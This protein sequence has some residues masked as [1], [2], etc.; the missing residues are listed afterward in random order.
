MTI[1]ET[2][3]H[4]IL[5]RP[6]FIIGA[7]FII[8]ILI[9]LAVSILI[10]LN[11][12]RSLEDREIEQSVKR[13][14]SGLANELTQLYSV[15]DDYA[16]W[17]DS[18]RF[19]VDGN[20][21]FIK[22]DLDDTIFPKLRLNLIAFVNPSGRI[23]YEKGFDLR[24]NKTVPV[25]ASLHSRIFAGSPLVRHDSTDSSLSGILL[26]P[27]GPLLVVSRPILTSEYKGPVRGALIMGRFL[28]S[29][30]TSLLNRITHL[31]M[32]F[33]PVNDP[34]V[35]SDVMTGSSPPDEKVRIRVLRQ[36]SDSIAGYSRLRDIY[37][38]PALILRV[39]MPRN[40]FRQGV[41]TIRYFVVS[42]FGIS[43][44]AVVAGYLL[45][46]KLVLTRRKQRESEARYH[47][48]IKQA[49]DGIMLVDAGSKRL[50][51]A[52]DTL[53][54]L[55][56]YSEN[57]LEGMTLED[58][59]EASRND[60]D[61]DIE[62]IR[63]KKQYFMGERYLRRKTGDLVI[64][65]VGANF[66]SVGDSEV[67]CIVA[68][69]ITERKRAEEKLRR[70]HD[71]LEKRV[72]ERTAELRAKDQLLLQQSRQAAMG[73]MIGNIA[74]QW[75]Q[76]L[77]ALGIIVQSL[78]ITYE[79]GELSTEYL[80]S[81]ADSA[82]ELISHMSQTISDFRNYFKPDKEKVPFNVRTAVSKTISL[83]ED[84]F[85]NR[86]I[87]I[88]INQQD[89]PVIEGYPN[90]YS[91]VLLNILLNARDVIIERGVGTP[92]VAVTISSRNGKAL[93]TITDNAGGIPEEIIDKIFDPY[94]TTKDP[95]KGTGVG[96][97]MSKSIIEKNM[98][99]NLTVQNT[100][101]GA[102]FR[103]EV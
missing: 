69:D 42:I 9:Q 28:D 55:V 87:A 24:N 33:L 44:I 23:V 77:N 100:G 19:I 52:N 48:V 22:T 64:V 31:S 45:H 103:I 51:E 91:Q 25:P 47:A 20:A 18:Y 2:N 34:R 15:A 16:G 37:G 49:S 79:D 59:L 5:K 41:M 102:M 89:D 4:T 72:M 13:A 21:A 98:E 6:Q 86:Q 61:R 40:V 62:N 73:E 63:S 76:P 70:T 84:S 54:S 56:G 81:M 27:E 12:Y 94:F 8:L 66:L 83:I 3:W 50:L 97:F 53:L 80:E 14:A 11:S 29:T 1:S 58:I 60:M 88:E 26:L 35:P 99:G 90:E 75:R 57:E 7:G 36:S 67:L 96:L 46:A 10:F 17:D 38:K 32:Q 43:L 95:D 101:D 30:E 68:R 82:M 39:I 74:H 65:E 71:E 85:S 93:V 92:K 78:P